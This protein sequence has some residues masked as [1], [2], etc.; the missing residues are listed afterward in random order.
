R[1]VAGGGAERARLFWC[2]SLR[3]DD[4][5][6]YARR[7]GTISRQADLAL[8]RK[9][10]RQ[11]GIH[12]SG[13][14]NHRARAAIQSRLIKSRNPRRTERPWRLHSRRAGLAGGLLLLLAIRFWPN[15][16]CRLRASRESFPSISSVAASSIRGGS[17]GRRIWPNWPT[18]SG[19]EDWY[20]RSSFVRIGCPVVMRS[21]LAS[22]VGARL[23]GRVSTLFP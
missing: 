16:N 1:S 19:K 21:S 23:S 14:G 4:P 17:S 3:H 6:E 12:A 2:Q 9:Q 7:R 13:C 11:S 22:G 18:R 5:A 8:R 10:R 20:S 15:Q